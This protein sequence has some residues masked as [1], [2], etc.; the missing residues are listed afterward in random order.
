MWWFKK[1]EKSKREVIL[2]RLLDDALVYLKEDLENASD[3][4]ELSALNDMVF[5][6]EEAL[7]K[8]SRVA[9][10][11]ICKKKQVLESE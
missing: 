2:E 6:I 3:L 8:K 10:R 5:D 11:R 4:M 7:Q 1:K 9:K